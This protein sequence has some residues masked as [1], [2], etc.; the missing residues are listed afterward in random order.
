MILGIVEGEVVATCKDSTHV[1]KKILQVRPLD[2][3]GKNTQEMLLAMDSLDAGVG[4]MV[5]ITQEGWCAAWAAKTPGAP[6]DSAIIGIVD[7]VE[8]TPGL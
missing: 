6:I 5:L 4:D 8:V 7:E 2:P 3:F 1:G